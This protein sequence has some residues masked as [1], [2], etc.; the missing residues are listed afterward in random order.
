MLTNEGEGRFVFV[1]PLPD[2]TE[3]GSELVCTYEDGRQTRATIHRA[4]LRDA[5]N[6]QRNLRMAGALV[7]GGPFGALGVAM[8]G[9]DPGYVVYPALNHVI[10]KDAFPSE[11]MR[12]AVRDDAVRAW[13]EVIAAI[14]TACVSPKFFGAPC[15]DEYPAFARDQDLR[16]LDA[17]LAEP[18]VGAEGAAP[19]NPPIAR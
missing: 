14:R 17:A 12:S 5:W 18:V 4:R 1:Y 16:A 13:D 3:E 6:R 10:L 7:G 15:E 8:S 2:A 19:S 11:A 9:V